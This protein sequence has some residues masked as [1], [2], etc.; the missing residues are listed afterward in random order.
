MG[1]TKILTRN[2]AGKNFRINIKRANTE[3]L[4]E[5]VKPRAN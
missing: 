1:M 3:R 4:V 2:A 5:K